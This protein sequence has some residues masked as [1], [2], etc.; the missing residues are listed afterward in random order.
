MLL[1]KE[2]DIINTKTIVKVKCDYCGVIKE[3]IYKNFLSGRKN[4]E[5][6]S[7]V[8][9]VGT[10]CA[11]ITL[12]KRQNDYYERLID[13]CNQ[14]NYTLISNKDE[15]FNNKTYIKYL[16]P[17]HGI[18]SSRIS[19]F[20]M[21]KGCIDCRSDN[22]SQKYRFD[23]HQIISKITECGGNILNP[24]GYIN[25]HKKNLKIECPSCGRVFETSLVLF[26]QH[27]GQ[28]CENCK[29]D[30]SV[31]EM[32]IRK[33]L[34]SKGIEYKQEYWFP[35]CKDIK[36]LPFDFYIPKNNMIIEFDGRQHFCETDY[37][38]YD[39]EKTKRHDDIKNSYCLNKGIKIIRIPYT[40]IN[41]ISSILDKIFT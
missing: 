7:C 31:G 32:R 3:T 36:P 20:L 19:N 12:L 21:G 33:Y 40:K 39:F 41:K 37:F 30:E 23:S 25:N 9:C 11:E 5:K 13:M 17:V 16:C 6:D 22:A 18:H 38:T 27:G 15:I 4:I 24:D 35:D 28:V 10:K 1:T 29:S 8:N 34:E 14:K 2:K 26:T